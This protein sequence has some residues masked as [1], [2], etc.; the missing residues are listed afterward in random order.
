ML[1]FLLPKRTD[2][3]LNLSFQKGNEG[4]KKAVVQQAESQESVSI[5]VVSGLALVS[6]K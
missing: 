3:E 6:W 1:F 4:R 2:L 5:T